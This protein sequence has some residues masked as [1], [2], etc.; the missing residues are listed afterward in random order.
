MFH[1]AL[2]RDIP[3]LTAT[4]TGD[5][6]ID[7]VRDYEVALRQELISLQLCDRP[8]GFIIDIRSK[9]A[10]HLDVAEALRLMVSRLGRLHPDRTAIVASSGVTKLQA[11]QVADPKAR[12]FTSM[13]V[14]RNWVTTELAASQPLVSVQCEPSDAEPTGSNVH[15]RGPSNVD[16]VLT[17][18]AALETARRIG[19][20]AVEVLLATATAATPL[21]RLAA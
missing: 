7:T 14:A 3:L 10:L 16:V 11:R 15:V 21:G 4:R 6:S 2:E 20:A 1:F 5:W 17:P 8:T 13:I 9:V 18:A 19:D 12:V